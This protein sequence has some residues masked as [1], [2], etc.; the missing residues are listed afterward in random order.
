MI[1]LVIVFSL[2]NSICKYGV[3]SDGAEHQAPAR[4]RAKEGELFAFK[5]EDAVIFS[6]GMIV[7]F[8]IPRG[9]LQSPTK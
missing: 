1:I 3:L 4:S 5:L 8:V 7:L 2:S 6:S 9:M